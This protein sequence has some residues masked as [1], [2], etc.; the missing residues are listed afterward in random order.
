MRLRLLLVFLL[1]PQM[2]TFSAE[3]KT[4]LEVKQ[5]TD[6]YF[7]NKNWTPF[8]S[9][10]ELSFLKD[11]ALQSS[12]SGTLLYDPLK[13]KLLMECY[14][15]SGQL[16]FIFKN[17]DLHFLL[18]LPGMKQAWEGNI[19]ELEYSPEF[20]SHLKPLDLYRAISPEPFSENQ[21][22]NAYGVTD[23]MELEIA[24]PH[25][26]KPYLARRL[27]LN[28]KGQVMNE[29]FLTPDGTETTVVIR[30]KFENLPNQVDV[31]NSKFYF[32]PQTTVF[33]PETGDKTILAI[34]SVR[35]YDQLP[36][37]AWKVLL[38]EELQPQSINQKNLSAAE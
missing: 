31:L 1:F 9:E 3:P 27:I 19:F 33:H 38:P 14:G 6:I 10:V 28:S 2:L 32:A 29:T 7:K 37:E 11:D 16:V 26:G 13:K 25:Q 34:K 17:D 15:K 12:C 18:Y 5:G 30:E 8:A 21:A 24:K 36:S 35:L 22:L 20:D 4:I 23:G